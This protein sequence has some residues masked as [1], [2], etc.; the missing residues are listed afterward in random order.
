MKKPKIK[1]RAV[2]GWM[3]VDGRGRPLT[4]DDRVPVYWYRAP[5]K[6]IAGRFGYS[7]ARV[8]VT[9]PP[10]RKKEKRNG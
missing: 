3:V 9:E 8:L 4:V 6:S 5:A 2:L 10:Q 7:I 1:P